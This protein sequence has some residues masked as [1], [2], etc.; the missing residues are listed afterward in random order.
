MQ[1]VRAGFQLT[2]ASVSPSGSCGV[3]LSETGSPAII[4]LVTRPVAPNL[5]GAPATWPV[6]LKAA[7][8][9][10]EPRPVGP[11]QPAPAAHHWWV[12]QLPL[13]PAVTSNRL[14][15]FWYG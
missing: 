9:S 12:E 15:E 1:S 3:R 10:G 13:L 11:S 14:V 6:A 4:G 8:V 7:A 5:T 2:E